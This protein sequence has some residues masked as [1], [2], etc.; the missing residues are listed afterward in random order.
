MSK[1]TTAAVRRIPVLL[2]E[3]VLNSITHGIGLV[4][5][6][7]GLA[8]LV[9]LATLRGN[10]WHIVGCS[11]FGGTL[12]TLYASSTLYHGF[13]RERLKRFFRVMDH[14]CIFLLIAGT[15]T[16]FTLT[17]LR[18]AFGWTL[19]GLAW[20]FAAVGIITK[21]VMS[22]KYLSESAMPY[23][24]MGWMAVI[25]IKPIVDTIPTGGLVLLAAGGLS[26]TVG[27]IFYARDSVPYFHTVWHL[28]VLAGSICHYF[29]VILY[30]LPASA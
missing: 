30:V 21:V 25:A 18:G 10:A 11:V 28:F 19:F 26:Y 12:V 24:L 6:I 20:T 2:R 29:A 8:V 13:R 22:K 7:I 16:P 5:S 17:V 14:A 15:Y 9:V 27:V 1:S 4:L 23:L 3:E